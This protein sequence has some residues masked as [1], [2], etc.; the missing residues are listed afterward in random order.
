MY[1]IALAHMPEVVSVRPYLD[2]VPS[3][4]KTAMV[5]KLTTRPLGDGALGDGVHK[6]EKGLVGLLP[7]LLGRRIMGELVASDWAILDSQNK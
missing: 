1:L 5:G 7:A 3:N 4:E 2:P 6:M